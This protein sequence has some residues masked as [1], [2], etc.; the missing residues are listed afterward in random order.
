MAN[1]IEVEFGNGKMKIL[2]LIQTI[3]QQAAMSKESRNKC[4]TL[5]KRDQ[6]PRKS[7]QSIVNLG[8]LLKH[9]NQNVDLGQQCDRLLKSSRSSLPLSSYRRVVLVVH[10]HSLLFPVHPLS[11]A[12]TSSMFLER[13]HLG[14]NQ[15]K[16]QKLPQGQS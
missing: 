5:Q 14:M 12:P 6:S 1:F 15:E 9:W 2:Y 10:H 3:L 16:W 13:R 4:K 7:P 11:S 8:I